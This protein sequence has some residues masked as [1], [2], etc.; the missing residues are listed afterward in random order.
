MSVPQLVEA[1]AVV[2]VDLHPAQS[3]QDAQ[4]DLVGERHGGVQAGVPLGRIV[5]DIGADRLVETVTERPAEALHEAWRA[6]PIVS[7]VWLRRRSLQRLR[8]PNPTA[9]LPE[10]LGVRSAGDILLRGRRRKVVRGGKLQD[11]AAVEHLVGQA[12]RAL[13]VVHRADEEDV[14]RREEARARPSGRG[15]PR[16]SARPCS[17]PGRDL[18]R[19]GGRASSRLRNSEK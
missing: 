12:L 4:L 13:V 6:V 19:H 14:V 10:R 3:R 7:C 18:V 9:P 1:R 8:R 16:G 17:C 11:V 15:C 5:R 2:A